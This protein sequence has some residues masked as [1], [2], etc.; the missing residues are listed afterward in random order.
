M[1]QFSEWLK[2]RIRKEIGRP[3]SPSKMKKLKRKETFPSGMRDSRND[4][5]QDYPG[6]LEFQGDVGAYKVLSKS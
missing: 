1:K 6:N 3:K 4:L 2:N 5:S